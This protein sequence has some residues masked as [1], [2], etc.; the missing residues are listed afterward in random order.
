MYDAVLRVEVIKGGFGVYVCDPEIQKAN[1]A[2]K[3]SYKDPWVE[4]HL[5]TPEAVCA[6]I[7]EVLPKLKPENTSTMFDAAFKRAVAEEDAA[8][9][10]KPD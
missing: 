9:N 8:E 5:E 2:P 4:Y 1:D 10:E 7:S 3:S 6:F